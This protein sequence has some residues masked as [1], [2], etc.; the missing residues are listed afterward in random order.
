LTDFVGHLP[1]ESAHRTL[2]DSEFGGLSSTTSGTSISSV[3]DASLVLQ[4][5]IEVFLCGLDGH[6]LQSSG[7]VV[8]VLEVGSD[9]VAAGLNSCVRLLY[10]PLS[11]FAGSLA[12]FLG[13]PLY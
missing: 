8:G 7:S 2:S 4:D 13:I 5:L 1:E 6:T 12:N 9:V 10:L 11:G 3:R